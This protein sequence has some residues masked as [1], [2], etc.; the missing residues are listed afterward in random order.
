MCEN[1]HLSPTD[2]TRHTR[3]ADHTTTKP[4]V[5]APSA[6]LSGALGSA[7]AEQV[8]DL[9]L[10]V[11]T[12]SVRV[13]PDGHEPG[14]FSAPMRIQIRLSASD[15]LQATGLTSEEAARRIRSVEP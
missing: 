5:T 10:A 7:E 6:D 9:L 8:R 15:L 3:H 2:H 13:P 12:W 11:V 4:Q 1:L 14:P